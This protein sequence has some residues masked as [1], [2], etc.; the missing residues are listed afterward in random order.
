MQMLL[1]LAFGVHGAF[2]A[3]SST[4]SAADGKMK[5]LSDVIT[6]LRN[7][8]T[9]LNTQGTTDRTNW[10]EYSAWSE[11]QEGDKNTYLQQTKSQVMTA[12][13]QKS[14]AEGQVA[15]LTTALS[16]LSSDLAEARQSV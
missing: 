6:L 14:A 9:S 7:S 12:Q 11:K 2:L 1:L 8:I 15:Q 5:Q 3:R 16:A 10:D 13:A 4:S